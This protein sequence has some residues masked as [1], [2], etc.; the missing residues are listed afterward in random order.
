MLTTSQMGLVA[1]SAAHADWWECAE[2]VERESC[3][4]R[5][6]PNHTRRIQLSDKGKE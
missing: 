3:P 2:W 5:Y 6:Y 1:R 4:L